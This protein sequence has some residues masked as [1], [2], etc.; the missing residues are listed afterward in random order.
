MKVNKRKMII[1]MTRKQMSI[2]DLALEAGID[3]ATVSRAKRH[4]SISLTS[5][6]R[7]AKA[8]GMDPS[9]LIEWEGNDE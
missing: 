7:I 6:G 2:L 9:E 3:P 4:E 8:L 5:I 1:A